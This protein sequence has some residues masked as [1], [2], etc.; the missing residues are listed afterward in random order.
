MDK[1]IEKQKNLQVAKLEDYVTFR[2]SIDDD[3]V[4]ES[5]SNLINDYVKIKPY[6]REYPIHEWKHNVRKVALVATGYNR[7]EYLINNILLSLNKI[8]ESVISA[9]N[10]KISNDKK[11][12]IIKKSF[13]EFN[14][15]IE[16]TSNG[17]NNVVSKFSRK[18]NQ[19]YYYYYKINRMMNLF[20]RAVDSINASKDKELDAILKELYDLTNSI[21]KNENRVFSKSML[22][23]HI[24]AFYNRV[25]GYRNTA[26]GIIMLHTVIDF[27]LKKMIVIKDK[28]AA[29]N[30]PKSKKGN[31]FFKSIEDSNPVYAAEI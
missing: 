2:G 18:I 6:D 25:V 21:D 8:D 22:E 16:K 12:E 11:F 26:R 20:I 28:K 13:N 4:N 5:L 29:L 27:I 24:F 19:T 9:Y 3:F 17:I 14:S 23:T 7:I 1:Y 31:D 15:Y 10:S 30:I